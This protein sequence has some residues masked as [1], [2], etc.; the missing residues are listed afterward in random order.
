MNIK[1][2]KLAIALT[3]ALFL[4]LPMSQA[5]A[6]EKHCE[7]KETQLGETMKHMKSELRAYVKGFKKD[8]TDKMQKHLNELLKLSEKANQYTPVKITQMNHEN[9][10]G[11][12]HSTM[13]KKEMAEMDHSKMDMKK[14]PEMDHSKMDHSKM[15][16]KEMAEMDHS[17][18][19]M[20]KKPEM[21]HS[22]MDHSKM[23]KKEMAEMDH[24]K[25]DHGGMDM[26][27]MDHDMAAMPSMEGMSLEQHHQHMKYMQ[28][29]TQLQDLFKQ[30]D[31]AKGNNEI[32]AILGKIKEHS[33]KSHQQFRQDC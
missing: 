17:K 20:K 21:D 11:M 26:D 31:G 13:D 2:T 32:K 27:S 5:F 25:M 1:K 7:I 29:M 24:S 23:D 6:H 18:M 28:G 9:K 10:K 14:K 8:D 4:T 22:K 30:L 19:D 3:G 16:K 15:D 33:R 12:D